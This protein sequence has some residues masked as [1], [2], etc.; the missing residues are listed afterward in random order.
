MTNGQDFAYFALIALIIV[1]GLGGLVACVQSYQT[2]S[3]RSE[4]GLAAAD[5]DLRPH[6]RLRRKA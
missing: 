1:T 5:E 4:S 6:P 2:I 3:R